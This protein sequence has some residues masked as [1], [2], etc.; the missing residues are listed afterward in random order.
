MFRSLVS[1]EELV[2]VHIVGDDC[3]RYRYAPGLQSIVADCVNCYQIE[4]IQIINKQIQK[5][6]YVQ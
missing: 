2:P 6:V 1:I 3:M 4:W 5:E